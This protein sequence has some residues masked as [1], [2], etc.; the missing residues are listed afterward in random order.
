MQTRKT[1]KDGV[2]DGLL[3][4]VIYASIGWAIFILLISLLPE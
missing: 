1:Y 3:K 2:K 4:G